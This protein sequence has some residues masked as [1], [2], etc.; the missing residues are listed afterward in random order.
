MLIAYDVIAV[1]PE[2]KQGAD[3]KWVSGTHSTGKHVQ[4]NTQCF[5]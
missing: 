1:S 5:I 4:I 2:Q 3:G